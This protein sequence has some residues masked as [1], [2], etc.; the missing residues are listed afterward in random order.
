MSVYQDLVIFLVIFLRDGGGLKSRK[1]T[2]KMNIATGADIDARTMES[3]E[4]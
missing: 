1:S 4:E 2:K 3:E